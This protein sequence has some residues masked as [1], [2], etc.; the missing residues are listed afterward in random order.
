MVVNLSAEF[1]VNDK[2]IDLIKAMQLTSIRI[3]T[4][5]TRLTDV[6]VLES[7]SQA[8][9]VEKEVE[10][11]VKRGDHIVIKLGTA[12]QG[13]TQ[14]FEGY[15]VSVL[16][17]A[18]IQIV[19]WDYSFL[20]LETPLDNHTFK[21]DANF[22]SVMAHIFDEV[23]RK[24]K[25]KFHKAGNLRPVIQNTLKKWALPNLELHDTN[26]YTILQRLNKTLPYDFFFRDTALCLFEPYV[27]DSGVHGEQVTIRT[28]V[29]VRQE[30]MTL[31]YVK[32]A[33]RLYTVSVKTVDSVGH[34]FEQTVS[35]DN[36][37]LGL[38]ISKVIPYPKNK[39][40][41]DIPNRKELEEYLMT[42]AKNLL[43]LYTYDGFIG[44]LHSRGFPFVSR[45][46]IVN[47]VDRGYESREG[48]YFAD[49]VDVY[50]NHRGFYRVLHLSQ[51]Q[52]TT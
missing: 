49:G 35:T 52:K 28:D 8:D 18:R 3:T 46:Y 31:E 27:Q 45:G 10:N 26:A 32:E 14:E 33:E 6:A 37:F 50:F 25:N 29:E 34:L 41:K 2:S 9:N 17:G 36:L 5:V 51:K 39:E 48:K 19:C 30:G 23:N 7:T 20:A 38:Y 4:A 40:G 12:E 22:E 24:T 43:K 1:F 47:L 11:K 44:S 15:V 16:T 42:Y 13:V 21:G